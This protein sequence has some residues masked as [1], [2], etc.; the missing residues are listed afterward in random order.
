[1]QVLARYLHFGSAAVHCK[2]ELLA[3]TL[4]QMNSGALDPA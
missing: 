4:Y 3:M 2:V 1:M